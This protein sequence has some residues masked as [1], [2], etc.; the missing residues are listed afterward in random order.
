MAT[1]KFADKFT[2]VGFVKLL[3]QF[4]EDVTIT[5]PAGASVTR[6]AIFNRMV[7]A[8]DHNQ[9]ASFQIAADATTGVAS[10]TRGYRITHESVV[11]TV[12]EVRTDDDGSHELMCRAP[13][14][15]T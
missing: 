5:T 12:E 3:D 2:A 13:E 4:G 10:P 9:D 7:F 11:W 8:R 6:K 14:L 15:V 1:S